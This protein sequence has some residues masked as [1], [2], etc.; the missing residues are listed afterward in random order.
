LV[1]WNAFR[2]S[3]KR[4]LHGLRRLLIVLLYVAGVVVVA[5]VAWQHMNWVT[6]TLIAFILLR[7][8]WHRFTFAEDKLKDDVHL[9]QRRLCAL[10]QH[11]GLEDKVLDEIQIGQLRQQLYGGPL[12]EHV[13]WPPAKE[14]RLRAWEEKYKETVKQIPS[15]DREYAAWKARLDKIRA[16][17]PPGS[18]LDEEDD[19]DDLDLDDLDLS[20]EDLEEDQGKK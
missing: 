6:F 7:H 4:V 5:V 10:E 18:F 17:R 15:G 9:A 16:E 2:E 19:V 1:S 12:S 11:A 20:D 14:S 3:T 13:F 8:E